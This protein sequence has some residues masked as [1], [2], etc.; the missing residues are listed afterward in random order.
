MLAS[1]DAPYAHCAVFA[2]SVQV[3]E[4]EPLAD[5][6]M[7]VRGNH[8]DPRF[9]RSAEQVVQQVGQ[10]EVPE[11]VD[12]EGRF[13]SISGDRAILHGDASV[14]HQHVERVNAAGEFTCERS[15]GFE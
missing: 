11:V 5:E 1:F 3:G 2:L 7:C 12:P 14:V 6:P 4:I 10:G 15:D 13:K 9:R 8:H